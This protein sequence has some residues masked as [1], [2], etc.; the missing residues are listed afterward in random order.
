MVS[1]RQN[2]I[3]TLA[4]K[5]LH[6]K[7][8]YYS[9]NPEISDQQYD[10]LED[11]LRK[12]DADH[13]VLK[14]VGAEPSGTGKKAQHKIPMLSLAKTY[15]LKELNQWISDR[16]VMATLKVDGNSLSLVYQDGKLV[17]AKTRGNGK[18]GEV[19][20]EKVRW[21]SDCA[22]QVN[23]KEEVEIRGELY[24]SE[25]QFLKLSKEMDQL[26]LEKPSNP[27]NTVAGILGRK[28]YTEL[29]R[30]FN[31]FAFD[32]LHSDGR[33]PFKTEEEKFQWLIKSG[34]KVPDHKLI[35]TPA[36]VE[37]FL[38][39]AKGYMEQGDVGIDGVVFSYND[40]ALFEELGSTSHHPRYRMSFKWQG[41][42][43]EVKINDFTWT[44]SRLGIVTPVAVIE[45][46]Y[47]SGAKITNV[48]LHNAAHVK[49]FNLKVG[50]EIEIVRSGEVIPKFLQV[51]KPAEGHYKW[52]EACPSCKSSLEFDD[53]RLF[54]PNR[55]SCPAQQVGT[56]LN[57]IKCAE[58][59]DLSEKRLLPLIEI[60]LVSHMSDLYRLGV[61]EFKQIPLV[62][63]K[64]A[65]K[66]FDNIAASKT[67]PLANFLNGLGIQG[68]GL[69]TWENLLEH[70]PS[71][72]ELFKLK[73]EDLEAIDGFAE[74]T[75]KQIIDGLADKK[76]DIDQLLKAGVR[77][78]APENESVN[79][80][81]LPLSGKSFVITGTMSRGRS[82]I[83]KDIKKAGGK[84]SSS[85]SK[86]THALIIADPESTSSKAKKARQLGVQL[87]S[88]EK[89]MEMIN[90]V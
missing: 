67:M 56:I 74:K 19:V 88:E 31:F 45:P 68:A 6:H 25:S 55:E 22:G 42:T 28:Q 50:D 24:C 86:N 58:I 49:L 47:L 34:F 15:Q 32:V 44:T 36:A 59:D 7:R 12:L 48:T 80:E 26:K 90:A 64:M 87:W 43:A 3:S 79:T 89:L 20:T 27:R 65:K 69:V 73:P 70:H 52:P 85:V 14:I 4:E 62:K 35:K 13:P 18:V 63:D 54:C 39:F 41:E 82:E 33:S 23:F 9:G 66:L 83:E 57:W 76:K 37:S 51:V 17:L 38:E 11:R 2:D 53:V 8:A 78:K 72:E 5:I 1:K 60:G 16:P 71:I 84:T 77:P 21:V 61:D 30:H 81:G 10:A 75:A 29:A 40:N 46:T